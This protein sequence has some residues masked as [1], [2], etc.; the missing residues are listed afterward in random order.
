MHAIRTT[1]VETEEQA[2]A[3]TERPPKPDGSGG[4]ALSRTR[5]EASPGRS[6]W[7]WARRGRP[8]AALVGAS[9]TVAIVASVCWAQS[10]RRPSAALR[11]AEEMPPASAPTPAQT[12]VFPPSLPVAAPPAPTSSSTAKARRAAPPL[13]ARPAFLRS[14]K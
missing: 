9:A 12:L 2:T 8:L 5:V 14:R 4:F 6:P 11:I 7:S 10:T 13:G 1:I 3:P